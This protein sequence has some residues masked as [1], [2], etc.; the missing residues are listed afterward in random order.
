MR[1]EEG[2]EAQAPARGE[3]RRRGR[4]RRARR[5]PL[6]ALQSVARLVADVDLPLRMVGD[7]R[8]DEEA[9]GLSEPGRAQGIRPR[10]AWS[11][12]Q[13]RQRRQTIDIMA[14]SNILHKMHKKVLPERFSGVFVR[15]E[16]SQFAFLFS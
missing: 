6:G 3:A 5:P 16:K 8:G 1:E 2:R 15:A 14:S 7:M 10:K 13:R 12:R 9:A 4:G 11:W